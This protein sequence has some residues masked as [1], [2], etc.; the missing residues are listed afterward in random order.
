MGLYVHSLLEIPV[1][2]KRNYYVYL[3]DY[4]WHEPLGEVL[5]QNFDR[6]AEIASVNNAVVIRSVGRGTHFQDEVFSWHGINGEEGNEILPAILVTDR[7]P[8]EFKES[9]DYRY[10]RKEQDFRII[11]FPI[12]QFCHNTTE[13]IKYIDMLFTDIIEK[14]DLSNFKV[15]KEMKK[16]LGRALVDGLLLEPNVGGIGYDFNSLINFFKK[17]KSHL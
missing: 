6:M 7:H 14:R 1:E 5:S 17:R 10:S 13:A 9:Y 11:L 2:A 8:R 4:G 3:L 12:K 16:G 15:A